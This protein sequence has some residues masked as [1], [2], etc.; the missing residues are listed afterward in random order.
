MGAL[1]RSEATPDRVVLGAS[2]TDGAQRCAAESWLGFERSAGLLMTDTVLT[3]LVLDA[4][5]GSDAG[6]AMLPES[7][8]AELGSVAPAGALRTGGRRL[9]RRARVAARPEERRVG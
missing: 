8:V 9:V 1:V 3:T 6:R 2:Y 7:A 4:S 5:P